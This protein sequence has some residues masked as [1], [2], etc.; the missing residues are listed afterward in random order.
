M[1]LILWRH[2]EAEDSFPD[3][4]RKLTGKGEKQAAKMAAWLKTYLPADARILVSPTVRTRQTAAAL[5]QKGTVAE[6]VGTGTSVA[7]LLGIAGWPDAKGAVV[8][9]G[10]QPTLGQVA[11]YLLSDTQESWNIKKGAIWWFSNRTRLGETQTVLRAALSPEFLE[12][13][14]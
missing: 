3:Q 10:H 8:V 14:L 11:A 12:M 2:A 1:D 9:V 13:P 5:T 7:A 6:E 4:D